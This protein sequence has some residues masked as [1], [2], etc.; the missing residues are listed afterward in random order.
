MSVEDWDCEFE[1]TSII[2][3]YRG[4]NLA[5]EIL[6]GSISSYNEEKYGDKLIGYCLVNI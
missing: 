2:G 6:C 3:N 5:Y 1:I 4:A